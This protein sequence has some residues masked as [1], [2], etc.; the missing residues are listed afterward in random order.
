[1]VWLPAGV[2]A[3]RWIMELAPGADNPFGPTDANVFAFVKLSAAGWEELGE[4][5]SEAPRALGL[6]PEVARALFPERSSQ[7]GEGEGGAEPRIVA[8]KITSSAIHSVSE[9]ILNSVE[10]VDDGLFVVLELR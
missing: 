1:M 5:T 9:A 8:S 7:S 3:C 4:L 2:T 10:R 6:T